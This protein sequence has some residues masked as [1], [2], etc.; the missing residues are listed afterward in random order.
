M[1]RIHSLCMIF[2]ILLSETLAGEWV[3]I[4]GSISPNK[5][6]AVAVFPQ[7]AENIDQVDD[8]VLLIDQL[9]N[10]PIG[11]LEEISSNGGM[12]GKTTQNLTCT[13]SANSSI[14]IVNY[15][16]GRL[17]QSSQIYR[18]QNRRAKPITLPE[19]K[20]HPKGLILHNLEF[21]TNPGSEITFAKNGDITQ[22]AWGYRP[23]FNVDYA[24]HGLAGFEGRLKITYRFNFKGDLK[25]LNISVPSQ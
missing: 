11:P 13:W 9:K 4:K 16:A 17:M 19:V 7:K 18:I 1:K 23:D 6:L 8:T 24:K 10:R 14:L 5:K 25:L 2:L 15:R 12:W 20:T 22:N 3:I 21:T